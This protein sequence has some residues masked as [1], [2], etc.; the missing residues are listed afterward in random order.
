MP[1]NRTHPFHPQLASQRG[2][3]HTWAALLFALERLRYMCLSR[4][5]HVQCMDGTAVT[6]PSMTWGAIRNKWQLMHNLFTLDQPVICT[7]S[8]GLPHDRGLFKC[9]QGSSSTISSSSDLIGQWLWNTHPEPSWLAW[10]PKASHHWEEIRV[11]Q[12][13]ALWDSHKAEERCKQA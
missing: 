8:H 9:E 6:P 11:F 10:E 12:I 2:L 5:D 4:C 13:P 3:A 1:V 7:K